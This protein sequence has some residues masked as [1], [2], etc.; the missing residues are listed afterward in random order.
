ME[1]EADSKQL[2]IFVVYLSTIR[3]ERERARLCW[4]G[5]LVYTGCVFSSLVAGGGG[6]A[7]IGIA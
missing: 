6:V 4:S 2:L 5:L 3:R 1:S 7:K